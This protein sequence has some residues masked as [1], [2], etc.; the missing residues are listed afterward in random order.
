MPAVSHLAYLR[1]LA[2]WIRAARR[3]LYRLPDAPELLCYGPGNHGH[4]ALQANTTALSAFA[5]LAVDPATDPD[6]TGMSRDEL[7]ATALG[8]LRFTLHAHH[9]GA[10]TATPASASARIQS[11]S[12]PIASAV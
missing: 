10:G 2:P 12:E 8:M 9:S 3:H 5:V 11:S 1:T 6:A 7:L 4:W